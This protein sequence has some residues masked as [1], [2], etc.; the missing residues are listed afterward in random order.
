MHQEN[1]ISRFWKLIS[2]T[3]GRKLDKAELRNAEVI[4]NNAL[5]AQQGQQQKLKA[6]LG[7]LI[8]LRNRAQSDLGQL[9]EDFELV[10][11]ALEQAARE[12]NEQLGVQLIEKRR[13]LEARRTRLETQHT[14]LSERIRGARQSIQEN[15]ESVEKL[16]RERME[17]LA[18]K[19]H[20]EAQLRI[21]EL[22]RNANPSHHDTA[23]V[24]RVREAVEELESVASIEQYAEPASDTKLSLNKLRED[25]ARE[26]ATS[27]FR[28][29]EERMTLKLLSSVPARPAR[30]ELKTNSVEEVHFS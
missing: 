1:F 10:Q 26:G 30:L 11:G 28:E 18:R 4:Y 12:S 19:A 7:Q 5:N 20:A 22:G 3:F 8:Q 21:Q 6:A 25:Q 2:G 13:E 15:H 29:L 14:E 9:E 24:E 23:A 17:L 27:E 16:R